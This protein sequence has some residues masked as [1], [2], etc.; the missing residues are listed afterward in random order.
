MFVDFVCTL[1]AIIF[2]TL[3]DYFRFN[4][5]NLGH[6]KF[7]SLHL[8]LAIQNI[9]FVLFNIYLNMK[10]LILNSRL[11]LRLRND[12]DPLPIC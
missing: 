4:L 8:P 2:L 1:L 7:K 11:S 12:C 5:P 9:E 10:V 3:S 6:F